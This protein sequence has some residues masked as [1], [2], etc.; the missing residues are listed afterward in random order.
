MDLGV[1][2][3]IQLDGRQS[4]VENRKELWIRPQVRAAK[5]A[6]SNAMGRF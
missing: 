6:R 2:L 4:R 3:N 5:R 1:D